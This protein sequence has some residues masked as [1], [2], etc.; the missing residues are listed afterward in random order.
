M[1][2]MEIRFPLVVLLN[3]FYS[4]GSLGGGRGWGRRDQTRSTRR[5]PRGFFFVAH[6]GN[7]KPHDNRI[8]P[9]PFLDARTTDGSEIEFHAKAIDRFERLT[10][11]LFSTTHIFDEQ[12]CCTN[13]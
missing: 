12:M 9:V 5:R 4:Q 10:C 7:T 11:Y 13:R 6:K 8:V 1:W 2:Q 3:H